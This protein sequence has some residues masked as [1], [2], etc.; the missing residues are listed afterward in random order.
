[1]RGG[2]LNITFPLIIKLAFVWC[3][4]VIVIQIFLPYQIKTIPR[5]IVAASIQ[6][7][8]VIGIFTLHNAI[9][10]FEESFIS[11]R[12]TAPHLGLVIYDDCTDAEEEKFLVSLVTRDKKSFLITADYKPVG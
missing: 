10:M 12:R 3:L 2:Q 1:M 6:P 5:I 9:P 11:L 7:E 8:N 4:L